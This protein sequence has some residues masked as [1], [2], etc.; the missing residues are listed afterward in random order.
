M[1][2]K[3]VPWDNAPAESFFKTLKSE[4]CG[5]RT[6]R[7]RAEARKAIFQYIEVF[8]NRV[9]LHSYLGYRSPEAYERIS[10]QKVA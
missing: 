2:R 4:L 9:R 1:S 10:R 7:S 5:R 3:G 6:F 8:Y